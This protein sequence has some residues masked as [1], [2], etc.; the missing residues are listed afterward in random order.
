MLLMAGLVFITSV[1]AQSRKEERASNTPP[2]SDV[3]KQRLLIRITAHYIHTISQGQI[4]MDSAV[5]IPCKLY[6]LSP[7]L[8]YNEGY[9]D[10][11]PSAA[12]SLLDAGKVETARAL[13]TRLRDE[14]RLRLLIELGSYLVFRPGTAKADLQEASKYINEAIEISTNKAN[15]WKIEGLTLQAFLLEQSGLTEE[16]QEKFAQVV[17]LAGQT[18]NRKALA[19]A[20][21]NAGRSY[22]YGHPTRLSNFEKALSIFQTLQARE[23]EIETLSEIIIEHFAFKRF[24]VAEQLIRKTLDLETRINFHHRQYAYDALAYLAFRKAAYT[25]SI[26][27]SNKSLSSLASKADSVFIGLFYTRQA[28]AYIHLQKFDE[29]LSWLTKALENQSAE[30]RLY[31]YKAFLT[32]TQ[33]LSNMNRGAEALPLLKETGSRYPPFRCLKR[34]IFRFLWG[35]RIKI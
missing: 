34:C 12:S 27:Y 32:K 5:R 26:F 6:G 8:V 15:Q 9:S 11:K 16:S 3:A 28:N 33:V 19:Q 23:K 14:A 22:H 35:K 1:S 31:W 4:D 20:L 18:E 25:N 13:L 29:G 17:T 30:T 24:K 21:L 2:Y 10:G 7:L